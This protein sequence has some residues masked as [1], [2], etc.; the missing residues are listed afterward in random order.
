[1]DANHQ[2][3]QDEPDTGDLIVG[4]EKIREFLIALGMPETTDPYYLKARRGFPIG[5]VGTGRTSLIAS[6][7]RLSN[8]IAKLARGSA[9]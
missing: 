6:K 4:R 1:M 7:K 3:Q 8:H 5:N 2:Q 9:A